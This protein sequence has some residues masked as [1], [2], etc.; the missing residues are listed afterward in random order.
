MNSRRSRDMIRVKR[1]VDLMIWRVNLWLKD[2]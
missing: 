1:K 2:S